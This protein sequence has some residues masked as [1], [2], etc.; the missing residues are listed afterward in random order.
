MLCG[1]NVATCSS[2]G[3]VETC[4]TGYSPFTPA[5]LS[6]PT[7]CAN[8]C[9][10]GTQPNS[11]DDGCDCQTTQGVTSCDTS[12]G[13]AASCDVDDGWVL[14][15]LGDGS[16]RCR[17][18]CVEA[19]LGPQVFLR[20]PFTGIDCLTVCA[21]FFRIGRSYVSY[22]SDLTDDLN[23][24]CFRPSYSVNDLGLMVDDSFCTDPT[25]AGTGEYYSVADNWLQTVS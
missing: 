16:H 23:C 15:Q 9:L 14:K 3:V 7:R 11:N 17:S 18:S 22:T 20:P 5:D 12:S 19:P 1:T 8:P 4:A 25:T 6:G 13:W 24:G 21:V 2:T 10:T